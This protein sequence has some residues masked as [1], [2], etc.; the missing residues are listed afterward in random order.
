MK[1]YL[2]LLK[3]RLLNIGYDKLDDNWN[4]DNVISPFSRMYF[5]TKGN[6]KVYHNNQVFYL[7]PGYMYL[8]PSYTYSRYK[9]D[10]YHEQFYI[11]FLEAVANN[12]SVY[13][14]N[15]FHY[16]IKASQNDL[17]R[18]ERLLEINTDRTLINNDPKVYDNKPVLMEFNKKNEALTTKQYLETRGILLVLFS[19]FINNSNSEGKL[20]TNKHM[21]NTMIYI[22]EN[23]HEKLTV[24]DLAA[25]CYLSKDHFSR[26]FKQCF[27]VR[28]IKYIQ[29]RRVQRA[30]LLLL[31][32][33]DSLKEISEKV[34]L[35]NLSYF[36]KIF[37]KN[38]GKTPTEFRNE[39]LHV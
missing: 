30:Q 2:Q 23:L 36:I 32:T 15:S 11:S 7:K 35:E 17:K 20:I 22:S 33:S 1:D 38:T 8:I 5:I 34:G 14:L 3:L 31:T 37:K 12:L 6:A 27:G 21:R 19:K 24:E 29:S 10:L 18:F 26:S 39:K 28:P 16:E 9:C 25:Y 13:N 4:F